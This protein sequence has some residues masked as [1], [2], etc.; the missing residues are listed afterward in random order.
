MMTARRDYATFLIA[1]LM[2]LSAYPADSSPRG[3]QVGDRFPDLVLPA[4]DDG[5]PLS[6]ASFRGRKLVLHVWASW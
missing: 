6:I 3:F 4:L 1:T 5:R 2:L